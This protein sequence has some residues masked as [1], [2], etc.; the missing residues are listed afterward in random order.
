MRIE[1][2]AARRQ[3]RID[4]GQEVIVGVNKYQSDS[5]DEIELLE[6]DNRAVR[7]TQLRR[8]A[9]V[10]RARDGRAVENAL[11]ALTRCAETGIGNLLE[12]FRMRRVAARLLAKFRSRLRR[13]SAG[14]KP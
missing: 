3:A 1:E 11:N 4:S 13:S 10:K 2:A 6:V 9:D 7:D 5:R 14:I 8:I 12:L